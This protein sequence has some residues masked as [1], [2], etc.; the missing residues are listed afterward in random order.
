MSDADVLGTLAE[1]FERMS[2]GTSPTGNYFFAVNA[3]DAAASLKRA[4]DRADGY[5]I[6][7]E[8]YDGDIVSRLRNWRGLH[9]AHE[10]RLFDEA[11]G[12]IERLRGDLEVRRLQLEAAAGDA[13]RERLQ[14]ADPGYTAGISADGEAKT[15]PAAAWAVMDGTKTLVGYHSCSREKA[16]A[17][18]REYGFP[19][20]VPLYRSPTLTDAEREAVERAVE[21][22]DG[23]QKTGGYHSAID[24][25]A[26]TLRGLLERTK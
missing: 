15:S 13:E 14:S 5:T 9:L 12:E 1:A 3:A 11:A 17:W 8:A 10:G 22:L 24:D 20:V 19:D 2:A 25:D 18:A 4:V 16:E 26:A 7:K 23:W 6:A 21:T